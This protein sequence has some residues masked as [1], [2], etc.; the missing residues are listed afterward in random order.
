MERVNSRPVDVDVSQRRIEAL[1]MLLASR[2]PSHEQLVGAGIW[3]PLGRG[4]ARSDAPREQR[5]AWARVSCTCDKLGRG[6]LG[7]DLVRKRTLPHA[8]VDGVYSPAVRARA[9]GR[10][11]RRT[12]ASPVQYW[13]LNA[14]AKARAWCAVMAFRP[15]AR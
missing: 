4:R 15:L 2:V 6:G 1:R 14:R 3:R 13:P 7:P 9:M 11:P 12:R 8:M 10:I 5:V